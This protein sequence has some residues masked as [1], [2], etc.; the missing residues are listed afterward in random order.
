MYKEEGRGVLR[1]KEE[2]RGHLDV[3]KREGGT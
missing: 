2:G 1:C 3:R